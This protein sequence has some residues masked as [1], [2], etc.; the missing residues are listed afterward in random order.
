MSNEINVELPPEPAPGSVVLTVKGT[1]YQRGSGAVAQ[2]FC[3]FDCTWT[4]AGGTVALPWVSLVASG[5]L[6][7]LTNDET[8]HWLCEQERKGYVS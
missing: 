1:A 5:P 8:T 7:V 6:L 4:P 3:G 2:F